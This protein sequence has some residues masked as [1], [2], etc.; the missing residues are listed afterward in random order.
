MHRMP[1]QSIP[2]RSSAPFWDHTDKASLIA[3][4]TVVAALNVVGWG[5]LI[6]IVA[7]QGHHLG[8]SEIFGVGVGLTA[9]LLGARHA[10]DV[11]HIAAID[12]TS[13][14]LVADGQRPLGVGFWFS[15]GHST[16]VFALAVAVALGVS[17][18]I[19]PVQDTDSTLQ[20]SLALTGSVVAGTF[21]ILMGLANLGTL[22]RLTRIATQQGTTP[23]DDAALEEQLNRRGLLTPILAPVLR[24]VHKPVHMYPI[25]LLMGLGFDTATQIALLVLA[26][27]TASVSLPWYAVLVLPVLF[28][29]GMTLFDTADGVLM[30]YAY[31]W[32]AGRRL[33]RIAY[34]ITITTISVVAALCVGMLIVLG[35][36]VEEVSITW[37]PLVW[38]A[39]LDT[40]GVGYALVGLL[41]VTWVASIAIWRRRTRIDGDG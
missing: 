2:K 11:D 8:N 9:F 17:A 31:H 14:K 30:A 21:L 34:N 12:N 35:L 22:A 19:E 39:T 1:G 16:V 3:M 32:A 38:L 18:L 33:R 24:R 6:L 28:A 41:A 37:Q 23:Y 13:R 25:G 36:L 20:H 4:A 10:F 5:V 40:A 7:P 15:L 27:G 29:A 26:G